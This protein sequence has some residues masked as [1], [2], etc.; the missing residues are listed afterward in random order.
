MMRRSFTRRRGRRGNDSSLRILG[1]LLI[2]G[3]LII[4]WRLLPFWL[5]WALLAM[6]LIG[7]GLVLAIG[8]LF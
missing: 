7:A 5:L 2:A 8:L 1:I 3:G 4:L 6:L